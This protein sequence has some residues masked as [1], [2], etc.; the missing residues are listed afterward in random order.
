LPRSLVKNFN[1]NEVDPIYGQS[2]PLVNAP[3]T[4]IVVIAVAGA[5][6]LLFRSSTSIALLTVAPCGYVGEG[7]HFPAFR[8]RVRRDII[9]LPEY[10]LTRLRL[11]PTRHVAWLRS[12]VH[13][14]LWWNTS[15]KDRS[16]V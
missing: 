5:A 15:L 16:T 12:P 9:T 7:E 4:P 13:D 8:A 14:E 6:P 2:E 3:P 1:A 10:P 11:R